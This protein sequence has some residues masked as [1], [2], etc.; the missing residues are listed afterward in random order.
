MLASF[1]Y[2]GL[3]RTLP[4]LIMAMHKPLHPEDIDLWQAR[5]RAGE[6]AVEGFA[7]A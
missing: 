2:R 3:E 4:R 1:H 7:T 5:T 6:I